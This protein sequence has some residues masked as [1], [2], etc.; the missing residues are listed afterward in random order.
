MPVNAD[1]EFSEDSRT[2]RTIEENAPQGAEVG[3]PV[4]ASDEDGDD[5]TYSL[6]GVDAEFFAIDQES[7]QIEGAWLS[8]TMRPEIL[9]YSD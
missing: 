8:W 3:E 2:A 5:L 1:P 6:K 9:T 4:K 7:G